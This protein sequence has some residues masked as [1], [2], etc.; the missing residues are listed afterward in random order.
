MAYGCMTWVKIKRINNY[1]RLLEFY[2]M[3]TETIDRSRAID[4]F[5]FDLEKVF[6][7]VPHKQLV[8][9]LKTTCSDCRIVN[10]IM[11]I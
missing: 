6:D 3:V 2:E 8:A 1:K 11:I 5:Y 10:W 9:K 7:T 4:I